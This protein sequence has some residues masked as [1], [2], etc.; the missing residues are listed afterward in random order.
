MPGNAINRPDGRRRDSRSAR[1]AGEARSDGALN[2]ENLICALEL[3]RITP[4]P[5][6][7]RGERVLSRP[8]CKRKGEKRKEEIADR[9]LE[10]EV[11][12]GLLLEP[13]TFGF[14]KCL[15]RMMF[16]FY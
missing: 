16:K 7:T 9:S 13:I 4:L 15:R 2:G 6:R 5:L 12:G 14:A 11:A 10:G 3:V 1:R 8:L